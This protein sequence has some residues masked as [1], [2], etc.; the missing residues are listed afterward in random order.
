MRSRRTD[1]GAAD[2]WCVALRA[3]VAWIR[4]RTKS[5]S[6]GVDGVDGAAD[7]MSSAGKAHAVDVSDAG[8]ARADVGISEAMVDQT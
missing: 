4:S 8:G 6:D 7:A 3:L 2:A 5:D 1:E